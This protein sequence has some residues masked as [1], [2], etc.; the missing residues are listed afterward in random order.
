M[1]RLV[2]LP[3]ATAAFVLPAIAVY[4]TM[5]AFELPLLGLSLSA[6]LFAWLFLEWSLTPG[7][8]MRLTRWLALPLLY[9]SGCAASLGFG[10]WSGRDGVTG[11]ELLLL[12][13]TGYWCLVL[14]VVAALAS[15]LERPDELVAW[16]AAGIAATAGLRLVEAATLGRHG[17]VPARWLTPNDYGMS[18]STFSPFLL[19]AALRSGG[20]GVWAAR[21]ALPLLLA[22]VV[23]NGSRSSWAG[24][25]LGGVAL[26]LLMASAR[27]LRPK[28]VAWATAAAGAAC[29]VLLLSPTWAQSASDRWQTLSR[30]DRDKPFQTRRLLL[31]KGVSLFAEQPLFGA[32][33]GR[34]SKASV[35][36]PAHRA[37]WATEDEL[38][39]RS[40]HNAYIKVLAETGLAGTAPLTALLVALF[41]SGSP[42]ALALA[43]QGQ[44]WAIAAVASMTGLCLHL[45][46]LSGLTNTAP[47][48]IFGL[49]AAAAERVRRQA[50]SC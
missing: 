29:A 5:P 21:A 28:R 35:E 17:A 44:T 31:D 20:P 24:V 50:W 10:V 46:T 14:V 22:A 30:L 43:R 23:V 2:R 37:P 15:R 40:P 19:A 1:P 27:R 41:A 32:G 33:L 45:W 39:Q 4:Q 42:A 6:P 13:R 49:V 36:L 16:M 38:N 34:F 7:S 11:D 25:A 3:T 8:D 12:V 18:F 26:F 9:W 48:L 47:W